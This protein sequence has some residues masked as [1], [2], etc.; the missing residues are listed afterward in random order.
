MNDKKED[1][2]KNEEGFEEMKEKEKT[3][4]TKPDSE[5]LKDRLDAC[6][7][8]NSELEEYAKRIKASM[9]NLRSEKD[10]EIRQNISYANQKLIERL[11]DILDDMERIMKNFENKESIEYT[12]LRLTQKKFKSLLE[13]EGL[14]EIKASGKF[15][16]FE[17]DAV[18]RVESEDHEDWDIVEVVLPG[19][20]FKSR[21]IRPVK[22]KV[23]MHVDKNSK[24]DKASKSKE[25]E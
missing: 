8:R 1:V 5:M 7:K 14:K 6:S 21:T 20:K 4:T 12:A 3:E 23:A 22:V 25:G 24:S 19:Y 18:E 16:P 15:D 9:E 10:E 17:H 2:K 11:I 13:S